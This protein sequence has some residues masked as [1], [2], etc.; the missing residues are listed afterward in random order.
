MKAHKYFAILLGCVLTLGLS[1]CVEKAPEYV[2]GEANTVSCVVTPDISVQTNV[3]L[4][5]T[6]L[7]VPFIR[8]NTSGALDC[9]V[10]ITDK[11]GLFKLQSSK[12]S[13]KNGEKTANA[14]VTYDYDKLDPKDSYYFVVNMASE[15]NASNYNAVSIPFTA[16]KAWKNL[17]VGEFYDQLVLS[18][19]TSL[20]I[21]KCTILQSPDGTQRYRIMAP[22]ADK[23][24]RIASWGEGPAQATPSPYIEFWV[25]DATKMT[26]TWNKYWLT[27]L[28]YQGV[29][30]YDIKA[31]L[32]S[33]LNSSQ[34]AADAYSCFVDEKVIQFVPYYYIDDLGGFGL[35][36]CYLSLPGGPDLA[37]WLAE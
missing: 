11:S 33:A 27:G 29:A 16:V 18:T 5:G 1:S 19:S 2:P 35:Y 31:Y 34:A 36:A 26:V 37:K 30:G 17:G 13:F 14:Y 9:N 10:T 20:G 24:Q 23:D 21:A 8:S 15:A 7:E 22:Y 25:K 6:P 3:D 28:W 12:I 4:N 32:P